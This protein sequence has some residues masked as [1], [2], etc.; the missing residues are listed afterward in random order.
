MKRLILLFWV[1]A[2]AMALSCNKEQAQNNDTPADEGERSI[3]ATLDLHAGDTY[4][5]VPKVEAGIPGRD[6]Y[7]GHGSRQQQ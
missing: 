3:P 2:L 1:A 4:P 6:L 7:A 5:F